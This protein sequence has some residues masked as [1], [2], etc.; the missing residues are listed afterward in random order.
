MD[1]A[2]LARDLF[3]ARQHRRLVLPPSERFAKFSV[4]DGY[5]VGDLMH[6][7]LVNQGFSSVGFKLGFTNQGIWGQLG[8]NRPFWAHIYDRTV[9]DQREANLDEF[10][11]P[12]IEPEIVLGLASKLDPG[13]SAEDVGAAI[14]WAAMGFEIVQCHFPDWKMNPADAIADGGLH[15]LLVLGDRREMTPVGAH[16]LANAEVDLSRLGDVIAR[17][18]GSAALG[19]PVEAVVWLL[20]LPGIS[21]LQPGTI[22]TTGTLTP[23]FDVGPGERWSASDARPDGLGD[24]ELMFT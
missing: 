16:R 20:S 4:D 19:G 15:G 6:Q 11:A 13:A 10:V 12:R 24:V 8:L 14:G 21:G 18:R 7:K 5:A 17:G 1:T 22:I 2:G 9:T 23:A 3:D